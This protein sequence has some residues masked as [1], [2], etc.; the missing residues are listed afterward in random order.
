M[1]AL[2]HAN[3]HFTIWALPTQDLLW[4]G[5]AGISK[6]TIGISAFPSLHVASAVLFALYAMRR[7]AIA[8]TMLWTFAALIMLGSVVLGW[9]Y[10]VDGYAGALLTLLTWKMVGRLLARQSSP[11]LAEA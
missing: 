3:T 10:A 1:D 2:A 5:Y 8:G 9:H 4:D 11:S 7:S 6:G